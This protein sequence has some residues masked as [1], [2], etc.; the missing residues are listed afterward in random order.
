MG[1]FPNESH[2]MLI[3]MFNICG[4]ASST[5]CLLPPS[6]LAMHPISSAKQQTVISL[7]L[8]GYSCRD[9]ERKTG[10]GKSIIGR[11]A[12]EVEPNKENINTG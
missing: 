8:E 1:I 2:D 4:Y 3:L 5:L 11:I 12:K 6:S 9:I 7:L 10:I